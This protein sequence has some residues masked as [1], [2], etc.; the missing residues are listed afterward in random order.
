MVRGR[1]EHGL[2]MRTIGAGHFAA[3]GVADEL[4]DDALVDAFAIGHQRRLERGQVAHFTAIGQFHGGLDRDFGEFD[5]LGERGSI[6]L[7]RELFHVAVFAALAPDRVVEFQC[8]TQGIDLGMAPGAA[9]EFLMFEDGF[10]D[11]GGASDVRLVD[12]N[13]SGRLDL[14]VVKI[15]KNLRA[16]M[17]R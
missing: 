11:G 6:R 15:L 8:K 2:D 12:Q 1:L 10:A 17:D 14:F 5:F 7:D 3:V 9:F 16:A 13:V 4:A